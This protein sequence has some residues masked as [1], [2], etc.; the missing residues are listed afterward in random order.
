MKFVNEYSAKITNTSKEKVTKPYTNDSYVFEDC[1]LFFD[2]EVKE[3]S[4][5]KET[6][7]SIDF[8]RSIG[9][10]FKVK[11]PEIA[12]GKI[13]LEPSQNAEPSLPYIPN[14]YQTPRK[15]LNGKLLLTVKPRTRIDVTYWYSVYTIEAEYEAISTY[16]DREIKHTGTWSGKIYVDDIGQVEHTIKETNLD[17]N[18]TRT[19]QLKITDNIKRINL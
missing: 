3:N 9:R 6:V 18:E 16:N 10:T 7:S 11:A 5:F 13:F 15:K 2:D 12:N 19:I 8:S 1:D 4:Y 17:T 14:S